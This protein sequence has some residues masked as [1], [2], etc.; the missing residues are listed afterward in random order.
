MTSSALIYTHKKLIK[1]PTTND[2][3]K[4]RDTRELQSRMVPSQNNWV[5]SP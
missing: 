1:S 2:Q 3:S 4:G 5:E